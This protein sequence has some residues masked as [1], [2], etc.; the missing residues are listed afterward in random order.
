MTGATTDADGIGQRLAAELLTDGAD[1][2]MG[3]SA[4]QPSNS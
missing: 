1:Q 4:R 3:S 2:L